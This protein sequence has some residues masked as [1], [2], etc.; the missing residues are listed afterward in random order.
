MSRKYFPK[1]ATLVM[2]KDRP[3]SLTLILIV[4]PKNKETTDL[5]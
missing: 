4:S 1:L 5:A 3:F 2:D